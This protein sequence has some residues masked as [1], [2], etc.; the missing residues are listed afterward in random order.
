MDPFESTSLYLKDI[1]KGQVF[2][3]CQYGRNMIWTASEDARIDAAGDTRLL[4]HRK[5][6]QL[7]E[8]FVTKGSD[9]YL[10]LYSEP[11]YPKNVNGQLVYETY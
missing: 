8:L 7:E 11:E 5:T 6:G 1:K 4:A 3:E 9:H 10:K 2:Y